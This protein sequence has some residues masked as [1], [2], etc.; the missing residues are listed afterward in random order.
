MFSQITILILQITNIIFSILTNYYLN[1]SKLSVIIL[2][3]HKL[4]PDLSNYY[5]DISKLS[6]IIL[7]SHKLLTL[8]FLFLQII[9][10]ILQITNNIFSILANYYLN[11]SNY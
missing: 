2:C 1:I 6:V 10:L 5:I 9:I 3:S 8:F 4:L 11:P 7:C